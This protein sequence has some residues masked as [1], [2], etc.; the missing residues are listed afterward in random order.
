VKKVLLAL[1]ALSLLLDRPGAAK[2]PLESPWLAWTRQ[3]P[4][5]GAVG[6][7]RQ[8]SVP[9]KALPVTWTDGSTADVPESDLMA[10]PEPTM[11]PS[12]SPLTWPAVFDVRGDRAL[13]WGQ[14]RKWGWTPI[15]TAKAKSVTRFDALQTGVVT[16]MAREAKAPRAHGFSFHAPGLTVLDAQVVRQAPDDQA[17]VSA[18]VEGT[19]LVSCDSSAQLRS[20]LETLPVV[21][22]VG[23]SPSP[24]LV[25]ERRGDWARVRL[26]R[27][28]WYQ[29]AD[30][31]VIAWDDKPS[32]WVR[33]GV[34]GPVAG[35]KVRLWSL[36][37]W[38]RGP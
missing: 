22:K 30:A 36:R 11:L 25:V 21:T 38:G 4:S 13:V 20:K 14:R 16:T 1:G 3:P 33:L 29:C 5:R 9:G 23:L 17:P 2:P 35:T 18:K 27:R 24:V 15:R 31:A 12:L 28:E 10:T 26:P 37:A 8:D 7:L 34:A 6:V 19:P 32:G